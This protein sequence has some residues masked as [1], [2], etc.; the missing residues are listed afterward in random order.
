MAKINGAQ[1][2]ISQLSELQKGVVKKG[3]PKKY[4]KLRHFSQSDNV[5]TKKLP[6]PGTPSF[7]KIA[8]KDQ[9]VLAKLQFDMALAR[10]FNPYLKNYQ[11]DEPGMPFLCQKLTELIMF[12]AFLS[13]ESRR[14]QF[15]SFPPMKRR[16][17]LLA[18][19]TVHPKLQVFQFKPIKTSYRVMNHL[20]VDGPGHRPVRV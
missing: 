9:L 7:D 20:L 16:I 13:L 3:P 5:K 11:T 10:T 8:L 14:E 2:D 19:V 6:N 17:H 15:L 12:E 4:H 18:V 1:E